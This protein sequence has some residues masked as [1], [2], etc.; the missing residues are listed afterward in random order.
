M[1]RDLDNLVTQMHSG[2]ITYTEAVRE[3]KKR[4]ILEVLAHHKGN[5]CKAAKE[6]QM[7]RNTLSRTIAELEINPTEV[8]LWLKRPSRSER[9]VFE[10]KQASSRG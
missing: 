3:F 2:G 8:R 7:H 6:L 1:R 5:Q 10:A 4:F 9:P